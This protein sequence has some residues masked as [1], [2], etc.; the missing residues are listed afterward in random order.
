MKFLFLIALV[1]CSSISKKPKDCIGDTER[2][3]T[4]KEVLKINHCYFQPLKETDYNGEKLKP[5]QKYVGIYDYTNDKWLLDPIYVHIFH[6]RNNITFVKKLGDKNYSIINLLDKKLTPTEFSDPVDIYYCPYGI[7]LGRESVFQLN[8]DQSHIALYDYNTG[9]IYKKIDHVDSAIS[10]GDKKI[11]QPY[12]TSKDGGLIIR[13]VRENGSKYYQ[14]YSSKGEPLS[15]E[16]EAANVYPFRVGFEQDLNKYNEGYKVAEVFFEKIN[17][18]ED[19]YWPIFF[20]STQYLK[21]PE[22]H[23]GYKFYT[24]LAD[25]NAEDSRWFREFGIW[26]AEFKD[27]KYITNQ[28]WLMPIDINERYKHLSMQD[29]KKLLEVYYIE[30]TYVSNQDGSVSRGRRMFHEF[31]DRVEDISEKKVYPNKKALLSF[32]DQHEKNVPTLVAE[33]KNNAIRIKAWDQRAAEIKRNNSIQTRDEFIERIHKNGP[34]PTSLQTYYYDVGVY[35]KYNGPRCSTYQQNYRNLENSS[36]RS[37]ELANQ[38]RLNDL[39]NS[40]SAGG[41][42]RRNG[43]VQ[44]VEDLNTKAV[45][46]AKE[47]ERVRVRDEQWKKKR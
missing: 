12:Y 24:A 27:S 22:N 26:I 37:N 2:Y 30:Y 31:E 34:N 18:K 1:S 39:Y 3:E 42:L 7:C 29:D 8:G 47:K 5:S 32:L 44:D 46:S 17:S 43:I 25:P 4:N 9:E 19:L 13:R 28:S 36:N 41:S 45:N 14:V 15:H 6:L 20:D 33:G 10:L 35:C 38:K 11:L 16:M 40:Q 23:K 21:K